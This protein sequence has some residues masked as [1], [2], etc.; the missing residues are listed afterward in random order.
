MVMAKLCSL[1]NR[2]DPQSVVERPYIHIIGRSKSTVNEQLAYVK[3]RTEALKSLR[4][5]VSFAGRRYKVI[6]RYNSGN[7]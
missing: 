5:P 2:F 7:T 1:F 6:V 4:E 3:Y